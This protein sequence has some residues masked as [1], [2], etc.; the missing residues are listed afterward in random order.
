WVRGSVDIFQGLER[1]G[2]AIIFREFDRRLHH[3][4]GTLV[5]RLTQ[6]AYVVP[7]LFEI[8]LVARNRI[9]ALPFE[10]LFLVAIERG[11]MLTVAPVAIGL[12]FD[13]HRAAAFA[14]S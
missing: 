11:V 8:K 7:A 10:Q 3:L 12:A 1:F 6:M 2:Q 4:S 13:Q 9:A 5:D 14:G